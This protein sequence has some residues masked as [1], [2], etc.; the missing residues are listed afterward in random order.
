MLNVRK[1]ADWGARLPTRGNSVAC[2]ES[3]NCSTNRVDQDIPKALPPLVGTPKNSRWPLACPTDTHNVF[4]HFLV[5]ENHLRKNVVSGI[6]RNLHG[7]DGCGRDRRGE[8]RAVHGAGARV[9]LH[10]P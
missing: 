5:R 3:T 7:L 2:G 10:M 9:K 6:E 8:I 4:A 1:L